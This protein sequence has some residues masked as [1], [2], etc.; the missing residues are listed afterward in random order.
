MLIAFLLTHHSSAFAD[1]SHYT[2]DSFNVVIAENINEDNHL[3]DKLSYT[4]L[5]P[6]FPLQLVTFSNI[7]GRMPPHSY[8]F[9]VFERVII[10]PNYH[11]IKCRPLNDAYGYEIL[12]ESI[13]FRDALNPKVK[14]VTENG[15]TYLKNISRQERT[16]QSELIPELHLDTNCPQQSLSH[17]AVVSVV[18]P[19]KK[20][21]L[22][23]D[24]H[25]TKITDTAV[26]MN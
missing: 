1:S 19:D 10:A 13:D 2:E 20:T 17:S 11:H 14:L 9:E 24:D 4:N 7:G 5:K 26:P 21:F 18:V 22:F 6:Y 15:H 25:S 8:V 12:F 3:L 16:I 23:L